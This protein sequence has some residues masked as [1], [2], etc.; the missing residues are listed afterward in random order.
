MAQVDVD[1]AEPAVSGR[2]SA[3]V[4]QRGTH[5]VV[6]ALG[7]IIKMTIQWIPVRSV[8]HA[9]GSSGLQS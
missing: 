5:S 3:N 4:H 9:A 7:G 8:L 6:N 2:P 1:H